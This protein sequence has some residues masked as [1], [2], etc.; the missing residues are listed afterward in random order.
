M[1]CQHGPIATGVRSIKIKVPPGG[2][3]NLLYLLCKVFAHNHEYMIMINNRKRIDNDI[4]VVAI[5][6]SAMRTTCAFF[7][8]T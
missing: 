3:F 8:N 2:V 4:M 5:N 1:A 7:V 6:T